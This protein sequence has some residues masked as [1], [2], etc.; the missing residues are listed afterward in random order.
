M[1]VKSSI[2]FLISSCIES[3]FVFLCNSIS[4][5]NL[6]KPKGVGMG[7][8]VGVSGGE[9]MLVEGRRWRRRRM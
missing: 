1:G 4:S 3:L 5:S 9:S 7:E 8:N 2:S 6:V